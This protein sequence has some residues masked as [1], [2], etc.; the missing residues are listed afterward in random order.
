MDRQ[1]VRMR[2]PC[3]VLAWG[4]PVLFRAPE[5]RPRLL[6]RFLTGL[7]VTLS[8]ETVHM[9]GESCT[10]T[11]RLCSN[12]AVRSVARHLPQRNRTRS[13]PYRLDARAAPCHAAQVTRTEAHRHTRLQT[14]RSSRTGTRRVFAWRHQCT[15]SC[16]SVLA[17]MCASVHALVHGRAW[18]RA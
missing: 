15:R 7:E 6:N 13:F 5:T 3:V 11:T 9:Y 14:T 17:C 10:T 8:D 1:P 4:L 12:G 16:A 2:A 18:L